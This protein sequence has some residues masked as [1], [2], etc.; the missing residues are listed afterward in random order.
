MLSCQPASVELFGFN[1]SIDNWWVLVC[2][3]GLLMAVT[4]RLT[5]LTATLPCAPGKATLW[6]WSRH[7]W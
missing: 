1:F 2:G 5:L 6:I 4:A 3:M 7:W